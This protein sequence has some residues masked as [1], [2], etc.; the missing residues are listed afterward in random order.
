MAVEFTY[1][2]TGLRPNLGVRHGRQ[3]S[4]VEMNQDKEL[5]RL[6]EQ[7]WIGSAEFYE[8]TLAPDAFM[9]F[10][11]P[12]GIL[13]RA[14]TIKSISSGARWRTASFNEQHCVMPASDTAVLVYAAQADRGEPGSEYTAQCSSTYIRGK[15][16]WQ[17]VLHHQT[18][19]GQ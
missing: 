9:V 11:Q 18:P 12:A 3:Y 17:L 13:D 2:A 16:G 5:W 4:E 15:D 6:E 14:A 10:P 8:R 19:A 1:I 7:F